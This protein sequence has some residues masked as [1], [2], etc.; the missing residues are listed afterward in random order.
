M[1]RSSSMRRVLSGTRARLIGSILRC[2]AGTTMSC[3]TLASLKADEARFWR[4]Q[5]P[6]LADCDRLK[7]TCCLGYVFIPIRKVRSVRAAK[8][9]CRLAN[10]ANRGELFLLPAFDLDNRENPACW[11]VSSGILT[12][13]TARC[14]LRSRVAPRSNSNA[15]RASH[16]RDDPE[17]DRRVC[18]STSLRK[19]SRAQRNARNLAW[20]EHAGKHLHFSGLERTIVRPSGCSLRNRHR[21]Q[22]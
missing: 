12:L 6:V 9:A 13:F 18:G 2:T 7:R 10:E 21:S 22:R 8:R 14:Y 3:T 5:W 1:L 16:L 19:A 15:C 20:L 11:W 4:V 17:L